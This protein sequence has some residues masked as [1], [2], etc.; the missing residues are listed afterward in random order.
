[1]RL[2][3]LLGE[4]IRSLFEWV[5]S[6]IPGPLGYALRWLYYK[7]ILGHLG[8]GTL[9]D[10]GVRIEHPRTVSIGARSW[11]DRNVVILGAVRDPLKGR[12]GR[13]IRRDPGIEGRVVIG[14]GVHVAANCI[15]SGMSGLRVGSELT[16]A[17]G[18]Y[19]YSLSHHYRSLDTGEV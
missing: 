15:L 6:P 13:W 2:L 7:A 4:S 12:A 11:I 19:V 16:L 18:T 9:I 10:V 8:W 1:M 5:L 17:A 3:W 14:D